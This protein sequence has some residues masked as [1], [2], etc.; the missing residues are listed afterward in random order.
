MIFPTPVTPSRGNREHSPIEGKHSP[1]GIV[2][3]EPP[4]LRSLLKVGGRPLTNLPNLWWE[5]PVGAVRCKKPQI[6][7]IIAV[8]PVRQCGRLKVNPRSCM[9]L[10]FVIICHKITDYF[11]LRTKSTKLNQGLRSGSRGDHL[12][13]G[14]PNPKLLWKLNH[15]LL[16]AG[17]AS[18]ERSEISSASICRVFLLGTYLPPF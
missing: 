5:I 3:R 10:G 6:F 1:K 8:G 12:P 14:G 13:G 11:R 9:F 17:L 7:H 2:F 18:V 4:C 16:R 15:E